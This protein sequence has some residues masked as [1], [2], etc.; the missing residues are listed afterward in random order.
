MHAPPLLDQNSV[1]C[2]QAG[3]A[4]TSS[5]P[6]SVDDTAAAKLTPQWLSKS[7]LVVRP[8]PMRTVRSFVKLYAFG[9]VASF[10]LHSHP[11]CSDSSDL[12]CRQQEGSRPVHSALMG[13]WEPDASRKPDTEDA[14]RRTVRDTQGIGNTDRWGLGGRGSNVEPV[15]SNRGQ[16]GWR[17]EERSS[18]LPVRREGPG[19][20]VP[21]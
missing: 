21:R 16:R 18:V 11:S 8:P 20:P 1:C 3:A 5:G 15:N 12:V 7:S 10:R 9:E 14:T 19:P 13:P 4:R 2:S 17:D 6:L